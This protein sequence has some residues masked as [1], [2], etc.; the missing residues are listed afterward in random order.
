MRILSWQPAATALNRL[1][2]AK[3]A[4]GAQTT[5][6]GDRFENGSAQRTDAVVRALRGSTVTF[7]N[8]SGAGETVKVQQLSP[9][10]RTYQPVAAAAGQPAH[11]GAPPETHDVYRVTTGNN[12]LE[13][14]IP[15]ELNPVD[16]LARVID[17]YTQT[18][19]TLRSG[20]RKLTINRTQYTPIGGYNA[21]AHGGGGTI[22]FWDGLNY[23][24]NSETFIHEMGH[25]IG[26]SKSTSGTFVPPRWADAAKKDGNFPSE[27]ASDTVTKSARQNYAEDFA[28]TWKGYVTARAAGN[29]VLERFRTQFPA[30]TS[31]VEAIFDQQ[32]S[33]ATAAKRPLWESLKSLRTK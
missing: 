7:V 25:I 27:Y 3:V 28:D 30:R 16:A 1:K 4:P 2:R 26:Q 20:L 21:P 33:P 15:Q 9:S 6:S 31:I 13:V 24:A 29:A 10:M 32:A 8:A 19:W 5:P 14:E 22:N 11:P 23:L 12:M 18:P 17:Y